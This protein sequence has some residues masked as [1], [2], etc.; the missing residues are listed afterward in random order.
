[1]ISTVLAENPSL[2]RLALWVAVGS[3][4]ALGWLLQHRRA[5]RSL[6]AVAGVALLAGLALTLS[7]DGGPRDVPFCTV[8]FSAPF[9]GLDTLANSVLLLPLALFAGL[10]TRRPWLTLASTSA[11]SAAIELTQALAPGL[12]R[13]CDTDDWWLNTVGAVVG[14][15]AAAAV[16]ALDRRRA[17]D[18]GAGGASHPGRS[19]SGGPGSGSGSGGADTGGSGSGASGSGGPGSGGAGRGHHVEDAGAVRTRPAER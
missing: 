10:A 14:A 1:M 7:P 18:Q 15:V 4:L 17:A 2:A 19:G 5:R 13:S 11:L 8:Q 3:V 12:G 9:T 6:T 16:L